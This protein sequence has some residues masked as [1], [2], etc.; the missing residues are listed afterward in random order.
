MKKLISLLLCVAMVSGTLSW[1]TVNVRAEN[2]PATGETVPADDG[3][4]LPLD[5][6]GENGKAVPWEDFD[7]TT[8]RIRPHRTGNGLTGNTVGTAVNINLNGEGRIRQNVLH[9]WNIGD[10]SRFYLRKA[11]TSNSF[12]M[13]FFDGSGLSGE[14]GLKVSDR[15]GASKRVDIDNDGGYGREGNVL[16]V[17]HRGKSDASVKNKQWRFLMQ[18]N[19]CYHIQNVS[20]GQYWSLKNS[21][22]DNGNRVV[23]KKSPFD[24]EIEV[25][26]NKDESRIPELQKKYDTLTRFTKAD[27]SITPSN[28][29][30][31]LPDDRCIGDISI[32]GVHDAATASVDL[33]TAG[34]SQAQCQQLTIHEMLYSGVRYFDLRMVS[35]GIDG[36]HWLGFAHG[37]TDCMY[38][39]EYLSFSSAKKWIDDFL[40][41]NPRETVIL[42]VNEERGGAGTIAKTLERLKDWPRVYKWDRNA[43]KLPTLGE[44]RGKVLIIS[45]FALQDMTD[46]SDI[47]YDENTNFAI[48]C[49]NWQQGNNCT[50]AQVRD[51][52]SFEVWT[53]DRYHMKGDEKDAWIEG[54]LFSKQTG[55]QVRRSDLKNA[56]N[57]ALIIS[58]TS[59]D[60]HTPQSAARFHVHT[61]LKE[62]LYK[63]PGNGDNTFLGVVCNDFS[64]EELAWLIYRR[65]FST[66]AELKYV[67]VYGNETSSGKKYTVIGIETEAKTVHDIEEQLKKEYEQFDKNNTG[68][69]ISAMGSDEAADAEAALSPEGYEPL[70]G[71]PL[72]L[73]RSPAEFSTLGELQDEAEKT[74]KQEILPGSTVT[75]YVPLKKADDTVSLSF[76]D[77]DNLSETDTQEVP[78]GEA[79][80][81][82]VPSVED[83]EFAGWDNRNREELFDF[84]QIYLR[85]QEAYA[86]WNNEKTHQIKVVNSEENNGTISAV[87]NRAAEGE[88]VELKA[89]PDF[90]YRLK[91][92]AVIR[93]FPA[94]FPVKVDSDSITMPDSDVIVYAEFEEDPEQ[95]IHHLTY[96]ERVEPTCETD[97]VKEHWVCDGGTYPCGGLFTSENAIIQTNESA[98]RIPATGHAWTAWLEA[99]PADCVNEGK[100]IRYCTN[101]IQHYEE[102]TVSANAAHKWGE[103]E[104][105]EEA[106]ET[107][108][109]KERRVCTLD[110]SHVEERS[111]THVH[112]HNFNYE[113][114]LDN[115]HLEINEIA[116]TCDAPGASRCPY[117]SQSIVLKLNDEAWQKVPYD[118]E[119]KEFTISGYPEEEVDGLAPLPDITC[120]RINE[121]GS[122]ADP[123][124][125]PPCERGNYLGI[126]NWGD[127][128]AVSYLVIDKPDSAR[129]VSLNGLSAVDGSAIAVTLTP[130]E[131]FLTYNGKKHV[132]SGTVLKDSQKKKMTA[133][134]DIE[135]DGFGEYE[136]LYKRTFVFSNSTNAAGSDAEEPPQV[137]MKLSLDKKSDIYK[138]LGKKEKSA[139][140]KAVSAAN[141]KLKAEGALT[142]EIRKRNLSEFTYESEKTAKNKKTLYF[143]DEEGNLL[144]VNLSMAVKKG[145]TA[146]TV[147]KVQFTCQDRTFTVGKKQIDR[148]VSGNENGSFTVTLAGAAEGKNPNYTGTCS[149]TFDFGS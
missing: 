140:A 42:Q 12:L 133:D 85:D 11:E 142:F 128:D 102:M 62:R 77:D 125:D 23:Q 59:C 126:V 94:F 10:S 54:S 144:T 88:K 21:G 118:G 33:G 35:G 28:W 80:T 75:L 4:S 139:V 40:N 14:E 86:D 49:R 50:T 32:P 57:D 16:H 112:I 138:S 130:L 113:D 87:K 105:V 46:E 148:S 63:W 121:D 52:G 26:D 24:W 89:D 108:D 84:D 78:L 116:A 3:N 53:Q 55:A 43:P 147:R 44:V 111:F 149:Y 91:K 20:S 109:G 2:D 1:T 137:Y 117:A 13:D 96:V 47:R 98:L 132:W 19:G 146:A 6:C 66:T 39:G 100:R 72:F 36:D 79:F 71:E 83:Y 141:K 34:N 135:A 30:S 48:E 110:P 70:S 119:P 99:R 97:G 115:S 9:L 51:F 27:G 95:H 124:A 25:V 103:W 41:V 82:P 29:M 17:V 5:A 15:K 123:I 65:N 73:S 31:M 131:D 76:I 60:Q 107:Q 145:V 120:Y 92:W 93:K 67:D 90:G 45:R 56:G 68:S 127:E 58:Y 134:F 18:E 101:D 129:T 64:D 38:N 8:I 114:Y 136:S 81:E 106:T 143:R 122:S 7:G 37:P 104:V 22:F 69:N 74:L 61:R